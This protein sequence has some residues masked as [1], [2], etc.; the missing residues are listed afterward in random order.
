MIGNKGNGFAKVTPIVPSLRIPE[1]SVIIGE[2]LDL[3]GV[4]C[5]DGGNGCHIVKV[6][7]SNTSDLTI[8]HYNISFMVSDDNGVVY[9]YNSFFDV[10][11]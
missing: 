10:V 9:R 6:L 8:G 11:S 2:E 7:P 3:S 1:L 4:E 5:I